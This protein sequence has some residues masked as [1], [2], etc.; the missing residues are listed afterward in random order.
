MAE[1][2]LAPFVLEDVK[3]LD[4]LEQK[5]SGAYGAV[6]EVTV[7]GVTCIA[8]RLHDILVTQVSRQERTSIQ[9]KFADECALLSKLRH[10]NVVHFV[11]VHYGRSTNDLSLVMECLHTDLAKFLEDSSS[12]IPLPIKLSI[13]LDVSYGL[14]YFHTCTPPI[15]HRDLTANNVLLTTDL[16]AK[17]A[18]LG[19]AKLLDPQ[20]QVAIAQTKA[21][22]SFH[23]MPPEALQKNP[24]Y[25]FKLDIFSFGH[26]SLYVASEK[27]PSVHEL[28][29]VT[30]YVALQQCKVQIERRREAI[31]QIG[32]ERHT[33]YPLIIQCLQDKVECRPTTT[34][35]NAR[36]KELC[37]KYPQTVEVSKLMTQRDKVH[38][39]SQMPYTRVNKCIRLFPKL[40][41]NMR[42]IMK[43][44]IDH[45]PKPRH[46]F[47]SMCIVSAPDPT[48]SRGETVW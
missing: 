43:A 36:L 45:T 25:D 10:P 47:G 35:L 24:V 33:L 37:T 12:K 23:Y 42:L 44:K 28:D 40:Q 41:G 1:K 17:I 6:Y 38:Y 16:R 29:D 7:K 20:K 3:G 13:L 22:G 34:E 26:L 15:I 4:C 8:K 31:E 19:V 2:E 14:L 46:F 27:L 32:G 18:D 21:P 5:G 48:L 9:K 39:V 30:M 11:G